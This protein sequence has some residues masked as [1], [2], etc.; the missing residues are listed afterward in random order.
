[1]KK[2]W[3][4]CIL[5]VFLFFSVA[6]YAAED[7][8]SI[9]DIYQHLST[10]AGGKFKK[11][12]GMTYAAP[13]LN[14]L[15]FIQ[16]PDIW[17]LDIN[18]YAKGFTPTAGNI[19]DKEFLVPT[20]KTN[21]DCQ[22]YSTCQAP[23]FTTDSSGNKRQLCLTPA[24]KILDTIYHAIVSAKQSIDITT[25]QPENALD[26]SFSTGAFTAAIQHAIAVLAEKSVDYPTPINI[27]FLQG[28]FL[29]YTM[30]ANQQRRYQQDI[31][32]SQET[33]LKNLTKSLPVNNKL[34]ITVGS[35]RSCQFSKNCGNEDSQQDLALEFAFNHGKIIDID[36][37]LL[38]TGGHNLLGE[39]YLQPNPVNDLS[40]ELSGPAVNGATV[41]ANTVWAYLCNHKELTR[42][43]YVTY[44]DGQIIHPTT[45]PAIINASSVLTR[46]NFSGQ[47]TDVSMMPIS[48]LNNGVGVGNDA[49]QSEPARVFAFMQAKKSIK[50]SQQ[51]M[52]YKGVGDIVT[53]PILRPINT[54][55]G[56]VM[57]ALAGAIQH[58]VDVYIVTS[59]LQ[60]KGDYSPYVDLNYIYLYLYSLL[61][62]RGVDPATAHEQLKTF[63]HL[64]NIAYDASDKNGDI[65]SH[66]K[67]WMVDD[68]VFYIGSHNIYPASLQEFGM[69]IDSAQ[70]ANY[71]NDT[72]WNP[73]WR[74][75]IP[76]KTI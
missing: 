19:I 38:I 22:G 59:N 55:D 4:Y 17:G 39:D 11:Y 48:K 74:N 76:F 18:T 43:I 42:N 46:N 5:L 2:C 21:S 73:L 41:Y 60:A 66:N 51:A 69:I 7:A 29:P 15:G 49:D 24:Y 9:Q 12:D 35:M 16:T 31:V 56:N 10:V 32:L 57:Q 47:F 1:M 50:I 71:V 13:S 36:N 58:G 26:S 68:K 14:S 70:V 75:A 34:I 72:L 27:R 28:S 54:V 3:K 61:E 52:F 67:F 44:Q 20:C 45:C 62:S 40:V 65:R 6:L 33:Y 25:L 30:D 63:L 8:I 23:D 37:S 53:R 64:A